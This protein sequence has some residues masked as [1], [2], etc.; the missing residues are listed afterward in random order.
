LYGKD[1][2]SHEILEICE[3]LELANAAEEHWIEKLGTTDPSRGFNLAKGGGRYEPK[4]LKRNPWSRPEYRKRMAEVKRELWSDPVYRSSL[5]GWKHSEQTRRKI[6]DSGKGKVHS[7][8]TRDKIALSLKTTKADA[9]QGEI[10][11]KKCGRSSLKVSF[12]RRSRTSNF[13][14]STCCDCN[15]ARIR[16]KSRPVGL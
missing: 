1:A 11:C 16:K 12:C 6:S 2:F 4:S 8:E 14:R 5:T 7:Q 9:V 3:T 13:L 10:F 15:N